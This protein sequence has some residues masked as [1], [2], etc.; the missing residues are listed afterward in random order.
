MLPLPQCSNYTVKFSG[1]NSPSP[2]ACLFL[3]GFPA[4]SREFPMQEKNQDIAAAIAQHLGMDSF[5]TH[6]RGLGLSKGRFSFI[7]SIEESCVVASAS[8]A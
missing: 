7:D 2:E 8:P 6:Y 3:H 5:V 1:A 4:A